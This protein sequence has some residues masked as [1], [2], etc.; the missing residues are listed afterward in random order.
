MN[1]ANNNA[2]QMSSQTHFKVAF[3]PGSSPVI[4]QSFSRM[5]SCEFALPDPH[6]PATLCPW[7]DEV[8]APVHC[9]PERARSSRA[10]ASIGLIKLMRKGQA[11][12]N[13][14]CYTI[15]Y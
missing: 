1:I 15:G 10:F 13:R 2:H 9:A 3:L 11:G 5:R 6:D 12:K 7:P 14:T 8:A 4:N